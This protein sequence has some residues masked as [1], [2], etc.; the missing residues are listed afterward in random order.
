MASIDR[1]ENGGARCDA[2]DCTAEVRWP[3]GSRFDFKHRLA[4]HGWSLWVNRGSKVYCPEHG[5]RPGHKM[6]RVV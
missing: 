5:P 6:R 3:W 2:T 1:H 4:E